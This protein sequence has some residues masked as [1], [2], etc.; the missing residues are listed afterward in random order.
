M[1]IYLKHKSDYISSCNY[2][3]QMFE[4]GVKLFP[5]ED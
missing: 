1:Y 4:V 2:Q 3:M 5:L